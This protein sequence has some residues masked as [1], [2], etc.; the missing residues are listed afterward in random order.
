MRPLHAASIIISRPD[1]FSKSG[2]STCLIHPKQV[3]L[4]HT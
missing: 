1:P 4:T 2:R 3:E